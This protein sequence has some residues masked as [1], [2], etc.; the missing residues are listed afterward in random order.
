MFSAIRLSTRIALS[1]FG[2]TAANAVFS[3]EKIEI[4]QGMPVISNR[5]LV[6]FK[7]SISTSSLQ[8]IKVTEGIDKQRAIGGIKFQRLSS[9]TKSVAALIASLK[10]RSDVEYVEP[11][12]QIKVAA[13]PNEP[14]FSELWALKN[15]GQAIIGLTGVAGADIGAVSAW[16]ISTGSRATVVGIV[17]TGVDYNHP[18]LAPNMWRAPT[19][20]TVK[21]GGGTITC[22]AGT[23]GFDAFNT[24]CDPMDGS[25]SHGTH[26]AGTIGAAGNNAQGVVGVNWTTSMMALKFTDD[27]GNGSFSAAIDAIEFA[28]QVK[29]HFGENANVRILSN[30]WGGGGYSQALLDQINRANSKGILFVAA[31]GN[32]SADIDVNPYY[33]A[34]HNT[35]NMISVAATENNDVISFYS[36]F[37]GSSVHL[38]APGSGIFSTYPY[39]SYGH[40]SGTSMATPLVSGAAAL[41]LSK[42]NL[43]TADLK[44]LILNTVDPKPSLAG[45]T[46]SGGRLNVNTAIN[47]CITAPPVN[48][49]PSYCPPGSQP[50]P[51]LGFCVDQSIGNA[52]GPFTKKMTDDCLRFGG[53]PACSSTMR[54]QID[55]RAVDVP[56]WSLSFAIDLRGTNTCMN[57]SARDSKHPDFCVEEAGQS[58][59][60]V[61]EVYGPFPASIINRCLAGNGGD[62]CYTNRWSYTYFDGMMR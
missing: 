24:T 49:T 45:R 21:L 60:G 3:Q 38:G 11:D 20:F 36:N 33:P 5:V 30:S 40:S 47:S 7:D 32:N 41:I 25:I 26:V 4:Y 37:S 53:G 2:L 29:A 39:N 57:G 54:F 13:I 8:T 58:Q 48:K 14:F 9:R 50:N 12:Y 51:A 22:P 17:D 62:A 16:D 52:Y 35:P 61:R 15:T 43:N 44:S 34:S 31:A 46:V 19:A 42:C 18:D 6:K 56:R 59:S 55:G 28:I 27:L 1:I 23:Y 10:K